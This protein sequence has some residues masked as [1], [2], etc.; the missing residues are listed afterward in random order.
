MAATEESTPPDRAHSTLPLPTF[1][2]IFFIEL[3]INEFIIQ[4]PVQLQILNKKFFMIKVP[5]L[6]SFTSG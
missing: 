1:S 3:S 2:L 4:L 5:F 6:E